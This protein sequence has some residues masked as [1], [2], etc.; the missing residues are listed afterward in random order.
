[1]TQSPIAAPS[2]DSDSHQSASEP[3][4]SLQNNSAFH[5]VTGNNE[6]VLLKGGVQ[7]FNALEQS[8]KQAQYYIALETYIFNF[9]A[10]SAQIAEALLEASKRG[11]QVHI[12]VDGVGT[13]SIPNF[14][15]KKFEEAGVHWIQYLPLGAIGLLFPSRWRRL[16][17]KLCVIDGQLAFCGGINILDD[18]YDPNHGVLEF[19]RWD[20]T[21]QVKGPLV[22]TID[23]TMK[24]LWLRNVAKNLVHTKTVNG[25]K[26]AWQLM[27]LA[28]EQLLMAQ[29]KKDKK[30]S[31]RL[32]L[33]DN[34]KNRRRIEQAYLS[35]FASAKE[36]IL[37]ANAYFLPGKKV[38]T[39]LLK[40]VKRGVRVRVLLQGRYEYFMQFYASRAVYLD[41][42]MGG[43]EI[44]EY[45]T[46]FL[47]AKVAVV[48]AHLKK[49]WCTV[50]S[51]NLDPL[52][53]LLAR[54][55]NIEVFNHEISM[56]IANEI[57]AAIT[58]S[59]QQVLLEQFQKR[60]FTQRLLN[61]TAYGLMRFALLITGKRY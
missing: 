3:S 52:S 41:L 29:S 36:E 40:A 50:G 10:Q 37:I 54:E 15:L 17:R 45:Q 26:N 5:P 16:H 49:S 23:E 57:E 18:F 55:A 13:P 31:E 8:F 43:V 60:N 32:L 48:D 25:V 22:Q 42:L 6:I 34:I 59:A 27:T 21:L 58:S 61:W 12:L 56:Q 39:A 38:R 19:A 24:V 14:W 30:P 28:N 33:R 44:Y 46:S 7:F 2:L 51:S 9:E 47:H 35:A 11:V 4:N 1:M 20:F 53:L